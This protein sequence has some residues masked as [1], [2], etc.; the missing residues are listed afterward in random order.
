MAKELSLNILDIAKKVQKLEAAGLPDTY[1]AEQV[2]MSDGVTS[3]EEALT[4][5][6][7]EHKVGKWIDGSVLYEKTIDFGALPK[8]SSKD[9]SSGL[10]NVTIREMKGI[11][12]SSSSVS[13][14]NYVSTES[15]TEQIRMMY[16]YTTNEIRI[17][18]SLDYSL[19]SAYVTI[20][21]TKNS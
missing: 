20:R 1:P 12:Y 18:T 13:P 19:L 10:T 14:L 7:T 6:T 11:E 3:V 4:Y 17:T 8:A 9:V 21:Y 5:S 16:R 15:I 2:M